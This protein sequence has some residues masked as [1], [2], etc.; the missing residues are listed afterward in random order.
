MCLRYQ[1]TCT[2]KEI[3]RNERMTPYATDVRY[4]RMFGADD[5]I[6]RLM[7]SPLDHH[8]PPSIVQSSDLAARGK[9][10]S[11]LLSHVSCELNAI[12]LTAPTAPASRNS[13]TATPPS[14]EPRPTSRTRWGSAAPSRSFPAASATTPRRAASDGTSAIG[15]RG[16]SRRSR[17]RRARARSFRGCAG[18]WSRGACTA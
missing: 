10:G 3:Q 7:R 17:T 15:P 1:Q 8:H 9:S 4:H 14:A 2:C 11:T 16:S 18:T 13:Q 12:S 6:S 5:A